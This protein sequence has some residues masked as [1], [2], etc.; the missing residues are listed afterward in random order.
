MIKV[1]CFIL[2]TESFYFTYGGKH[3]GCIGS[4]GYIATPYIMA[5]VKLIKAVINNKFTAP[6]RQPTDIFT[7]F[8]D[9]LYKDK[10]G[11]WQSV[12]AVLSGKLQLSKISEP[13]TKSQM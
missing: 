1:N 11:R 8:T 9:A 5:K 4:T 7:T 2:A 6:H 13:R 3:I 10:V 12:N